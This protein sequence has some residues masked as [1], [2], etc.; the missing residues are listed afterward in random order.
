MNRKRII[1]AIHILIKMIKN[2]KKALDEI[3]TVN[4]VNRH[5]ESAWL[6]PT[7]QFN[8]KT[9]CIWFQLQ[10][11][12]VFLLLFSDRKQ[13]VNIHDALRDFLTFLQACLKD[14]F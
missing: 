1:N 2:S 3:L 12:E 14:T 13:N 11:T 9:K 8:R 4:T 5:I 7:R 10:N 6:Y